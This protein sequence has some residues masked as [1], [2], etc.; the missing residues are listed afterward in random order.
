MWASISSGRD[1]PGRHPH[2]A[3]RSMCPW[4]LASQGRLRTK[5]AGLELTQ[6]SYLSP[7]EALSPAS[8]GTWGLYLHPGFT[9]QWRHL[10]CMLWFWGCQ[11]LQPPVLLWSWLWVL[12]LGLSIPKVTSLLVLYLWLLVCFPGNVTNGL[13]RITLY[14]ASSQTAGRENPVSSLSLSRNSAFTLSIFKIQLW[15]TDGGYGLFCPVNKR[16]ELSCPPR[17]LF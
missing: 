13:V 17:P 3:K 10:T 6:F 11:W 2:V 8:Q 14:L 12:L 1:S 9:D 4:S 5:P 16:G 15:A 7:L